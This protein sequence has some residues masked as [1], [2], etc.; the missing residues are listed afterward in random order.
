MRGEPIGSPLMGSPLQEDVLQR[1]KA[2]L[3][4]IIFYRSFLNSSL[5]I[6]LS[7]HGI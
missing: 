6:S 5:T 7:F 3:R 2:A 4:T 1:G